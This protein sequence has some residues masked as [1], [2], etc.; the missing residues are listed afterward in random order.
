MV[1]RKTKLLDRVLAVTLAVIMLLSMF[2]M[3]TLTAFAVS[4]AS[5]NDCQNACGGKMEWVENPT[6][7]TKHYLVCDNAACDKN[8]IA[9]A[10][11]SHAEG[12]GATDCL[13]C[14]PPHAHGEFVYS[15]ENESKTIVA[16]CTSAGTCDLVDGKV[17]ITIVAPSDLKY[18]NTVKSATIDGAAAWRAATGDDA[19]QITYNK[20]PKTVGSYTA[21]ITVDE[22]TASVGFEIVKG[23]PSYTVPTGLTAKYGQTLADVE[24][25][26]GFAWNDKTVSV[27]D[28]GVNTF[29]ASFTPTDTDNYNVVADIDVQVTVG[30]AA[31][32]IAAPSIDQE[33]KPTHTT[34]TLE[35]ITPTVGDGAVEYGYIKNEADKNDPSK[36]TNWQTETTFDGLEGS[37]TYYFYARVSETTNYAAAVSNKTSISTKDK[38]NVELSISIDNW[39]YGETA[40]KPDF[41]VSTK[42][43]TGTTKIEYAT[44]GQDN[45]SEDKP[46]NAGEYT[47]RISTESTAVYAPSDKT[48]DFVIEKKEVTVEWTNKELIYNASYQL[49]KAEIS[50]GIVGSDDITVVVSSE[51]KEVVSNEKNAGD[52]Y[53]AYAI[54]DGTAKNNY[55][56]KSGDSSTS[57]AIKTKEIAIT[58]SNTSLTHNK[59]KQKPTATINEGQICNGDEGKV[60]VVVSGEKKKP[61]QPGEKYTATASLVGDAATNYVIANASTEFTISDEA[62]P[63][64]PFVIVRADAAPGD[65]TKADPNENDWYNYDI[66][67]LPKEGYK[68]ST[69]V[70]NDESFESEL[71]I[72]ES[73]KNF[74]VYLKAPNGGYTRAI[75][76][77]E[78]FGSGKVDIN[79][80]KDL[81]KAYTKIN[82]GTLWDVFLETVTFGIYHK[83]EVTV[84]L[85]GTDENSTIDYIYYYKLEKN[86]LSNSDLF[87]KG[88]DIPSWTEGTTVTVDVDNDYVVY[89]KVVDKAGNISYASTKDFV[90]DATRPIV[91]VSYNNNDAA[92]GKYFKADREV[93]IKITE[94]NFDPAGVKL[95]VTE[96]GADT[97]SKYA[98]DWN[99][100]GDIHTAKVL[101]TNE[102]D[103]TFD[104]SVEDKAGNKNADVNYGESVAPE[105]FT[106]DRT[107][108][109]PVE[110]EQAVN[111]TLT[112]D[113]PACEV[114]H[115]SSFG[116]FFNKELEIKVN[117][118][119]AGAGVQTIELFTDADGQKPVTTMK[120]GTTDTFVLCAPY[121]GNLY[122][123]IIDK[124]GNATDIIKV[125]SKNSNMQDANGYVMLETNAPEVSDLVDKPLT[126]VRKQDGT[127]N[128]SGDAEIKFSAQDD[129]SGLYSVAVEVN[130]DAYPK[131]LTPVTFATQDIEIHNYTLSTVDIEP[132]ADGKYVFVVTVTDNAGNVTEKTLTVNKDKTAPVITGFDFALSSAPDKNILGEPYVVIEDY[133]YYFK[134]SVNVKVAAEDNKSDKEMASGVKTITVVLLDKDGKYYTVNASG[135][136][137]AITDVATEAVAHNATA[138]TFTFKIV[139]DFK[140][141]IFAFATDNVGNTPL[142]TAFDFKP[143]DV[144]ADGDLKGYKFPNGSVLESAAK[145]EATSSIEIKAP[146]TE[147][148]QNEAYTYIYGGTA[149]KTDAGM[150]YDDAQKV[151]LYKSNPT[152]EVVVK[153]EYSGIREIKVTVIENGVPTVKTVSIDNAGNKSGDD[154]DAWNIMSK[155]GNL[156][157]CMTNDIT[158]EGN[159]N[160]MV[161]L[162]E[163]TD[164]AGNM[165]YDYYVLG[166]DKDAPTI[167]VQYA[168]GEINDVQYPDYFRTNRSAVITV[169]ERNFNA[170]GVVCNI[171]KD[172]APINLVDLTRAEAWTSTDGVNYTATVNYTADGDYIFEIFCSDNVGNVSDK[173]T[174]QFTIDKTLPEVTVTYDNNNAANGNY[175]KADRTAT[176]TIVEHNFVANRVNIIGSATDNGK[177]SAFPTISNWT[178]RG[179]VHTATINYTVDSKYVF[180]ISVTDKAGNLSADFT[181]HEF[182]IDKTNPKLQI[183]GIVDKSANNSKGNIGFVITGTDTNFN[184]FT[185]VLS[186]VLKNENNNFDTKTISV[187]QA[188]AVDNGQKYTVTNIEL[189]GVYSI[190]CTFVDMA[191]NSFSE[192]ILEDA[193]GKEYTEKRS[194]TDK[195]IE[196]SVNRNGSTFT[197]DDYTKK[198]LDNYYVQKVT[199]DVTLVEINT[200]SITES[201]VTLNGK[202]LSENTDYTVSFEHPEGGWYRY[203]YSINKNLF[204]GEGEYNVVVSSKDRAT[205]DAFSDVKGATINFVVDR[206]APVITVSGMESGGRYQTNSQKVTIIPTDDGGALKSLVVYTVD[207]DGKQIKELVNLSGEALLTALEENSGKIEFAIEEGLYQ[208]I[209]I[210]CNDSS[211]GAD[212]TNNT[213]DQTFTNVSV[214]SSGFMIFWA[215]KSLRWGT[216][217][218][219]FVL[220]AAIVF[221]VIY[222]KH[223]K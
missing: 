215:N 22:K 125:D 35:A 15:L 159:S 149:E 132:D 57:F 161:F 59:D 151:P 216:I 213:Y 63:D 66:K 145:H 201:T 198:I 87:E 7:D 197:V 40:A 98:L 110:D 185:P 70:D 88:E 171:T 165:S 31:S 207:S 17:S 142:N 173:N 54:L 10:I 100:N 14:N 179:D 109:V 177:P 99:T 141:Q 114:L 24:L 193:S 189:D 32:V 169:S 138:N 48:A 55:V 30:K 112:N 192:V 208:N 4:Y 212:G 44:K 26:A 75:K 199:S 96:G 76:M 200:D 5:G 103:Y 196:F 188:E 8:D 90:F 89:V 118:T 184:G 152:F 206:T 25:P 29:K 190:T 39:T 223:K 172:G 28:S 217:A 38:L 117:A 42:E 214:N 135:D 37:T 123:K 77:D 222:K 126:D 203:T 1:R 183:S 65:R 20:E 220:A 84:T 195:L 36:V 11:T 133:G 106:I 139:D 47:V 221:F 3:S 130:G 154:R 121:T 219:G 64:E 128:Y 127:H 61:N 86:R 124:A 41:A 6:P 120:E 170:S 153:D 79:I 129:G 68:I 209:R 205:N 167:N 104:I 166:I 45:W 122:I 33:N 78:Y 73:K 58:W 158:V 13:L 148:T 72:T 186:A 211:V 53:T 94:H 2:P 131:A 74:E 150:S 108:P 111:I 43:Y 23:T 162:V 46:S 105:E 101:F 143:N 19:P 202:T 156:V 164:R 34:I 69:T 176:I 56:I 12:T 119:D 175:Y 218:G 178:S 155:E 102:A 83:D 16:T 95:T 91:E 52:N 49:P 136:V 115:F 85:S 71:L 174:A 60:E 92:N 163:L 181:S 168:G 157:T 67:I 146:E 107:I 18:D 82:E 147:S 9:N 93:T 62:V 81:P 187:G 50:S 27:G 144:K 134:E 137:V 194:E 116:L 21:S 180:D 210:I 113:T 140:G 182:Y 80:D 51:K 204:D 97:S 160:N 191:G